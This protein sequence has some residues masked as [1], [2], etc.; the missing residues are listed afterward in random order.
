M[1]AAALYLPPNDSS[2]PSFSEFDPYAI[3]WQGEL[4]DDVEHAD[5]SIG[6][7]EFLMSG[8]V[9]SGKSLPGAHLMLKHLIS[10]PRARGILARRAMPDLR[11]TIFAK[12][13]EHLEG[14]VKLDG[15][16]WKEGVDYGIAWNNCSLWL[17]NK[18]ELIS[19]SWADRRYKKV[20][21][22]EASCALVEELTENDAEDE[23][24]FKYLRMRVGRLPHVPQ[25]FIAY[26]TN[27]DAPSHFAYNYFE[28]GKRQ[29]KSRAAVAKMQAAGQLNPTRHVYF[30]RT[31][32]NPF[33]PPW[34]VEN[35]KTNMDPKL[36]RQ[37]LFGEWIDIRSKTIYHAYSEASNYRA[38]KWRV[39]PTRPI[40]VSWDF[41]IGDGKPLSLCLSQYVGGSHHFFAEVVIESASTEEAC[42]ELG[43]RGL[44]NELT[45]YVVHG[46]ATGAARSTQSKRS[47]YE[48]IRE[49]LANFRTP[50]GRRLDF[51]MDVPKSNPPVRTRH[52]T[53]NAYCKNQAGERRLFVYS[54]CDTLNE[55]LKK[56]KLKKGGNY[57][58]DDGPGSPYQH[59]TTAAG[60][61]IC[62]LHARIE[63][64][65]RSSIT[66]RQIR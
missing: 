1:T 58:E 49:F 62:R 50:D 18:S 64:G 26:M 44:L 7:H 46:D 12:V 65:G 20:G 13:C 35:L 23:A 9:G 22:I 32:D 56:T 37:M 51:E 48:I 11:D 61:H 40:Y 39:D 3:A 24:A 52:N 30:S 19:R 41:N 60:Y 66:E 29:G 53:V 47:N 57:V 14:S 54:G 36:A 27:P 6:A 4:I 59:I 63:R 33:L 10:Y 25:S 31:E 8:S 15:T 43:Q 55:G 45:R 16:L 2:T 21:S 38:S 17:K 28:I 42:E 5:Y 34:Y